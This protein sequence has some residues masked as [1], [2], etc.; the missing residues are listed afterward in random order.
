[1][2]LQKKLHGGNNLD[3]ASFIGCKQNIFITKIN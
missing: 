3:V 2:K 1:M